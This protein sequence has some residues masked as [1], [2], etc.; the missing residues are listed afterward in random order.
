MKKRC[1]LLCL[2]LVLVTLISLLPLQVAAET[3][4]A[5][6]EPK[7]ATVTIKVV[8]GSKTLFSYTVEVGDKPVTIHRDKYM[9]HNKKVYQF[10]DYKLSGKKVKKI[11]IPAYDGTSAWTKKWGKSITLVYKT[12]THSYTPSYSRIYHW[13]ICECGETTNEVRHV[14]PATDS[15]KICTCGYKFSDNADLT[16]LWLANMV[17]S[18]NFNKETTEYIGQFR[19]YMDVTSTTITAHTFDALAKVELPENLEIH[20]GANK[21]EIR[22]TAED[23]TAT[24]TYTVIAVKPV[25]VE[26]SFIGTDG[27][28]ITATLKPKVMLKNAAADVSE[29]IAEKVLEL[30]VQDKAATISLLPEFSKWSVNQ[31]EVT[32]SGDFLKAIAEKTEANLTLKTPYESTLTIP[33]A[34]LAGLAEGRTS[35]TIRINKDNT[36]ELLAVGDPITVSQDITLT[37][38][39]T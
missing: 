30:A 5:E 12:H 32:V 13:N 35:V 24:K 7:T 14:D 28:N 25:K 23:K 18:P 16:T 4:P 19:T 20:E 33:H 2:L 11:T 10:S 17:L 39:E 21:F 38:P 6:E 27:T 9:K 22:V 31:A 1:K 34:E 37:V 8:V 3:E 29:A 36:F 15:D 26:D